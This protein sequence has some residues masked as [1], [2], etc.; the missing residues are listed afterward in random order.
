M[1]YL[2]DNIRPVEKELLSDINANSECLS[3][4][5]FYPVNF[6]RVA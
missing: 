1:D 6:E 3:I 2:E 4:E 5:E